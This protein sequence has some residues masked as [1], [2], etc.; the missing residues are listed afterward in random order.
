MQKAKKRLFRWHATRRAT[1]RATWRA[2]N[3]VLIK[4]EAK[5]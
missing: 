4:W 5:E 3:D 1:W 2:E